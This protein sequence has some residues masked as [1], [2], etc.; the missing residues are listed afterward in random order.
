MKGIILTQ[1]A[2]RKLDDLEISRRQMDLQS[3]Q[4]ELVIDCPDCF[5]SMIRIYNSED[6]LEYQCENCGLTVSK[7]CYENEDSCT[8]LLAT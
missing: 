6:K 7:S 2:V 8:S 4:E 3:E 1:E 5:D